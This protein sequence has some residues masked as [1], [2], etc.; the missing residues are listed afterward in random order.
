V[1]LAAEAEFD[2]VLVNADLD[3]ALQELELLMG[4]T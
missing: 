3:L 2:A 4:L 1:E